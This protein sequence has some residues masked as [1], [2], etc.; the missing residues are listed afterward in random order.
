M[1]LKNN[2][3]SCWFE[4]LASGEFLDHVVCFVA[5]PLCDGFNCHF[6]NSQETRLRKQDEGDVRE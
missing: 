4:S 1:R 2:N 5:M 3:F 6:D